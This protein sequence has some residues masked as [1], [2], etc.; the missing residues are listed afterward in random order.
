[1]IT[2]EEK[3]LMA[4]AVSLEKTKPSRAAILKP[5]KILAEKKV[6]TQSAE[7]HV[8]LENEIV[9]QSRIPQSS[10]ND[11]WAGITVRTCPD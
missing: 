6:F 8:C 10:S 2:D 3:S 1:M 5:R 7:S 4:W 9:R 11:R